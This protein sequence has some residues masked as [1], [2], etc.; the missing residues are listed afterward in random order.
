MKKLTMP[1]DYVE[2]ANNERN[3]IEGGGFL[4]EVLAPTLNSMFNSLISA[5][6]NPFAAAG[7]NIGRLW[8][9]FGLSVA[10][11]FMSNYSRR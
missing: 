4:D 5:S 11:S 10:N 9:N 6:R 7:L 2:I 8:T 3:M 1:E